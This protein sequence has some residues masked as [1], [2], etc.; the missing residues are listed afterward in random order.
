MSDPRKEVCRELAE[1]LATPRGLRTARLLQM[2]GLLSPPKAGGTPAL[3]GPPPWPISIWQPQQ[4]DG[5]LAFVRPDPGPFGDHYAARKVL[6]PKTSELPLRVA[7]FGESVAAGYLYAPHLTP[8]QVLEAQ[9][10]AQGSFEVIDLARTNETLAGLRDTVRA[11]L[12]INPDI[13]VLFAGNNW[14][15]LETPEVSPYAPSVQARQRYALALRAGIEGPVRLA[16]EQLRASV[17]AT[18]DEIALLARTI[19]IPVVVVVPEVNLADWETRQPLPWLPGHRT[20]RWHSLYLDA[21]GRLARE[22]WEGTASVARKLLDLDGGICPSTWRLLAKACQGLGDLPGAAEACRREVDSARYATLAFLSAPQVTTEVRGILS[23][24]A[25]RNGFF[26]VDLPAIFA[27]HTGSPLPDRRL[28]L[29]YCHLTVEGMQVAMAAVAARVLDLSGMMETAPDWRALPAPPR[30]SPEADATAKL[31]AA[32]HC[33]HRLLT[34]GPKAPIL[35][36]WCEAALDASPGIEAAML[37]LIEA[38]TAPCPAVLT[39][40][41]QR[42]LA[43]PYRLS[44]QH[45]WRWDHLDADLIEAVC[46]VLERRGRPVR[47][48]VTRQLLEHHAIRPDGTDLTRPPYLWEPLERFYPEVMEHEDAPRRA[49]YRSPWP[50]STF[51]LV[52]DGVAEVELELTVRLAD[53]HGEVEV[54]VNG[55]AVGRAPAG[56]RW[57]RTVLSIPREPLR[58]GLNRLELRWPELPEAGDDPLEPARERLELGLAADLHPVFGEVWSLRARPLSASSPVEL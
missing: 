9:L 3:P 50:V 34:V 37:D 46:N 6:R 57:T 16:R 48:I 26:L 51:C 4:I 52:C 47:E 41:Q 21:A 38:R 7:F 45:G 56:E 2:Q 5:E 29:D 32:I 15:L 53:R 10:Q 33:A 55:R 44:L 14:N 25:R 49:T 40:A 39:K 31:G 23:D 43:S 54:F 19:G 27:E 20:A 8:A 1:R 11:S 36:H 22:D 13:L 18:L 12:Q 30:V 42:N 58:P 35:E 17:E 24:A 28:F